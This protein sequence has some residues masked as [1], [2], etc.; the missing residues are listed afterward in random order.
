MSDPTKTGDG[1]GMLGGGAPDGAAPTGG[2]GDGVA[3]GQAVA[4]T[5]AFAFLPEGLKGLAEGF[6][7]PE[8]FWAQAGELFGLA[9]ERELV[10]GKRV[11]DSMA[12]Q[13]EW[14]AFHKALGR[15]DKPEGYTLPERFEAE[16]VPQELAGAV[17]ELLSRDK[18][19][20]SALMHKHGLSQRQAEGMYRDIGSILAKSLGESQASAP[21]P[22]KV[23]AELWPQDT[24][25]N[26]DLAR[27]GA[28]AL[29]V[30]DALDEAGLSA[31]PLVLK[32]AHALGEM[33]A[34]DRLRDGGGPTA[35]MPVGQE[36]YQEMLRLVGSDAYQKNDPATVR[37]VEQLAG[38]VNMK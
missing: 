13:E 36:A 11:P 22:Q 21:D 4:G 1:N 33:T 9:K 23:V 31:H 12:S 15:P 10:T 34:E 16:G 6:G 20:F 5:E 28:R 25:K 24:E 35:P 8:E 7:K 26:L 38:R 19:E 30:G 27:R 32:L 17:S 18:G 29:G 14:E 3:A 2:G 37:R